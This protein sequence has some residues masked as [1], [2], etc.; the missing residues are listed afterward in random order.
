MKELIVFPAIVLLMFAYPQ[1]LNAQEC[2][3]KASG[4]PICIN[5]FEVCVLDNTH[6]ECFAII[7]PCPEQ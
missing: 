5:G 1:I 6:R 2:D 3:I 4:Y 7:N